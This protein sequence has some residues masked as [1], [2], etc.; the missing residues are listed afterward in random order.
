MKIA[1]E[2]I[3]PRQHTLNCKQVCVS[4][5]GLIDAHRR[6]AHSFIFTIQFIY[7]FLIFLTLSLIISCVISQNINHTDKRPVPGQL[8]VGHANISPG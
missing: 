1:R 2:L 8:S 4:Q 6:Y 3:A 5:G 7:L